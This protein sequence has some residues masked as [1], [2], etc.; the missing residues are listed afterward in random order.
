MIIFVKCILSWFLGL[1]YRLCRNELTVFRRCFH[2]YSLGTDCWT[3]KRWIHI[4]INDV[5]NLFLSFLFLLLIV[6]WTGF[7]NLIV[8][9]KHLKDINIYILLFLV[10]SLNVFCPG[11]PSDG[12]IVSS[13]GCC[14]WRKVDFFEDIHMIN[15]KGKTVIKMHSWEENVP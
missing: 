2:F 7:S 3:F 14:T 5:S 10:C 15:L 11:N 6:D 9:E 4:A 12:N 8:T 13:F 1:G